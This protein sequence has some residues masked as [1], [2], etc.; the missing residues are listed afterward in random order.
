MVTDRMK[1]RV[2]KATQVEGADPWYRPFVGK[3]LWVSRSS[4]ADGQ[5]N[6]KYTR[7]DL[8]VSASDVREVPSPWR[9]LFHAINGTLPRLAQ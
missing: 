1:V 7:K 5:Y 4:L 3:Y 2:L 9:K 8:K 6:L